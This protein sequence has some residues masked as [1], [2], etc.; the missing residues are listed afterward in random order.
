MNIL[1]SI[2]QAVGTQADELNLIVVGMWVFVKQKNGENR[3]RGAGLLKVE[4]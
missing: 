1:I 4:V 2:K 3:Y